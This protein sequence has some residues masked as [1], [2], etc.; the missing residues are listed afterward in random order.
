MSERILYLPSFSA[1]FMTC[2]KK[3]R[4]GCLSWINNFFRNSG[5]SLISELN[6]EELMHSTKSNDVNKTCTGLSCLIPEYTLGNLAFCS[7]LFYIMQQ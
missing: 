1:E 7:R 5:V 6:A 3:K 4:N 2:L